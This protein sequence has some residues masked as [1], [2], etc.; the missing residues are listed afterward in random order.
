MSAEALDRIAKEVAAC[1]KCLLAQGRCKA[2]PGEGSPTARVMFIGEAPGYHEDQQGRPFVGSSGQLLDH[3]FDKIKLKREDVFITNVVKCRPPNNRDP[4]SRELE[5]CKSYLDRQIAEINPRLVI[6]LGRFSMA[7]YWPGER[8]SLIHGQAKAENGRLYMPMFHPSFALR[9]RNGPGMQKFKEDGLTIPRMLKKAE[10]LARTE[11]WGAASPENEAVMSMLP[12]A[13]TQGQERPAQPDKLAQVKEE[14]VTSEPIAGIAPPAVNPAGEVLASPETLL[15]V[16]V[17]PKAARRTRKPKGVEGQEPVSL[18][19]VLPYPETKEG[20][21]P[22]EQSEKLL[23]VTEEGEKVLLR[24]KKR[25][26][27][28]ETEPNETEKTLTRR[29]KRE[30]ETVVE[31][32]KMF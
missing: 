21:V 32:L 18:E 14:S 28:T 2:V 3:L 6:T 4:E 11:L 23:P 17:A 29:K 31:Q 13:P 25:E 30:P 10:E 16:G 19:E 26:L 1:T 15:P 9:D 27:E 7:R 8:I 5:A 20:E 22:A 12:L 24:R